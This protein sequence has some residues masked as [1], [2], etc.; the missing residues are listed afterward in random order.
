MFQLKVQKIMDFENIRK[1]YNGCLCD[2]G[3]CVCECVCVCVC[4][5]VREREREREMY[6]RTKQKTQNK[7][8]TQEL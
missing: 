4:V 3:V 8:H 7:F 5:C 6:V 2:W 1:R